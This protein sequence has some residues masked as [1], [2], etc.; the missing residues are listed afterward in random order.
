MRSG[1]L[2]SCDEPITRT[3]IEYSID[4]T[5]LSLHVHCYVLWQIECV[6]RINGGKL[7]LQ[8]ACTKRH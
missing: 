5:S 1:C 2:Y 3:Q 8:V 4:G 7:T 6:A